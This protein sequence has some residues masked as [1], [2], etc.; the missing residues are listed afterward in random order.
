MSATAIITGVAGLLKQVLPRILTNKDQAVEVG[1]RLELELHKA[2]QDERSEFHSFILDFEGRATDMPKSVQ[3]TRAMIRP[4]L[5]ILVVCGY[6]W[7]FLH[8]QDGFTPE[9][10]AMLHTWGLLILGFWFGERAMKNLG[11]NLGG[12][13]QKKE[14]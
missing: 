12:L 13:V 4:I 5:T 1:E 11:V 14:A 3:I 7:G 6:L 10:M 9:Q 2:A 8:P